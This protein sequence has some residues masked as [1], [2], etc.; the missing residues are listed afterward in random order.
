MMLSP[1]FSHCPGDTRK[2]FTPLFCAFGSWWQS[3][4]SLLSTLYNVCRL[5]FWQSFQ[6]E[7][8]CFSF[9]MPE[10]PGLNDLVVFSPDNFKRI[11]MRYWILN[12]NQWYI[13]IHERL[14]KLRAFAHITPKISFFKPTNTRVTKARAR[15][16]S[17]HHIPTIIQDLQ[18]IALDVPFGMPA[19]TIL[20]VR[21][22][23]L[24]SALA[25]GYTDGLTFFTCNKYFH[26]AI[27]RQNKSRKISVSLQFSRGTK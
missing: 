19:G 13:S 10:L 14:K 4:K 7:A 6:P 27:L 25:K 18:N 3:V 24:V 20:N 16:M 8:G 23:R 26:N 2:G 15:W 11:F 12:C 1:L 22:V 9:T 17:N 21:A 5:Q